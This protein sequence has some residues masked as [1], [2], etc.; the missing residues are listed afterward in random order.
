[1]DNFNEWKHEYFTLKFWC[2]KIPVISRIDCK[3]IM[4]AN[5]EVYQ[6][7]LVANRNTSWSITSMSLMIGISYNWLKW[8]REGLAVEIF[9]KD[10]HNQVTKRFC[11]WFYE[12]GLTLNIHPFPYMTCIILRNQVPCYFVCGSNQ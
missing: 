1:M 7:F 3:I 6:N 8:K 4:S 11:F 9:H 12:K 10:H 2:L 5:S